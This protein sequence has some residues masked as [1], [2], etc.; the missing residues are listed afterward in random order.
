MY[1][2]EDSEGMITYTELPCAEERLTYLK[3]IVYFEE[4]QTAARAAKVLDPKVDYLDKVSKMAECAGLHFSHH[5][6]ISDSDKLMRLQATRQLRQ[7]HSKYD[8]SE[9]RFV[10]LFSEGFKKGMQIESD[11][12]EF[13]R[14]KKFCSVLAKTETLRHDIQQP[15]NYQLVEN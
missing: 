1:K 4:K 2:C 5:D 7:N 13:I 14:H 9:D 10:L 12:D 11:D 8:I 6:S 15:E 3:K